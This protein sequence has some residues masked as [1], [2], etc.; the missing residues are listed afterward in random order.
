MF[1]FNNKT[2]SQNDIEM[3]DVSSLLCKLEEN[4]NK[5]ITQ[6]ILDIEE[7]DRIYEKRMVQMEQALEERVAKL[8]QLAKI[9]TLRT[10]AEY[11]RY[12]LKS[13]GMYNIDPDGPL[14]GREPFQVF[15]N[16][17]TGATEVLHD[18]ENLTV[19]D[20]CHDPGNNTEY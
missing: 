5:K 13:S 3:S 1:L 10:C 4:Y 19:V 20:H 15:C 2:L 14:L 9:G 8:E 16:F 11:T 17:E 7:R 18:S 6:M 12:G